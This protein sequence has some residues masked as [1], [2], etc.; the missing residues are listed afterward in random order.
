MLKYLKEYRF[1]ITLLVLILIPVLALDS[2]RR[3]PRERKI[4]DKVFLW[5]VSPVQ[6]GVTWA[7]ET[8]IDGVLHYIALWNSN[9]QNQQLLENNR[10]L[11]SEIHQLREAQL[12]N[13]RLRKLLD[14]RESSLLKTVVARVI[15]RDVSTE[16]RAIRINRGEASGI[17]RG[18]AV[19]THEGIVGRVLRTSSDTADIVTILDLLSAV[20]AVV[21]RS[22]ARGVVEGFTDELCQLKFLVRTD[23][24]QPGDL[25]LSS[26]LG[27]ILPRGVPVGRVTEV[28]KKRFGISQEVEVRPTVDFNRLD[29]VMVVTDFSTV[30][31]EKAKP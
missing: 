8:T 29:E 5:L 19:L 3:L 17:R 15:A 31:I 30:A 16:F 13:D 27:N 4:Y 9:E 22:R 25:L 12:E 26:G 14:F 6:L 10:E 28:H 21:E 20:D 1:Y 7:L 23:D 11:L 24:V 18:M 2:E